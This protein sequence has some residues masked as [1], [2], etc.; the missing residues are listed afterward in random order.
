[1]G[2]KLNTKL[3]NIYVCA[4]NPNK[5]TGPDTISNRML[6]AVANE[7]SFP[8][9]ILF[10][11]SFRECKFPQIFKRNTFTK[12]E[13][14]HVHQTLDQYHFKWDWMW[15]LIVSVLDHCLS[16]YFGKIQ[17]KYVTILMKITCYM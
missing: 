14:I 16:F 12:R 5:A 4:I 2:T 15:D 6:K 10:N 17:K 1:M 11:V 3:L 13:I 8:L 9:E 7:V